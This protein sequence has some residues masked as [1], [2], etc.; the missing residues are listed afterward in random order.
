MAP[1][2]CVESRVK[3]R[4][5]GLSRQNE[6]RCAFFRGN[7]SGA[8]RRYKVP[9]VPLRTFVRMITFKCC[10]LFGKY[11]SNSKTDIGFKCFDCW[12]ESEVPLGTYVRARLSARPL[13]GRRFV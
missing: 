1:F 6:K 11:S 4:P 10:N 5:A 7:D 2:L 13:Q 8:P 12:P 3:L 9:S